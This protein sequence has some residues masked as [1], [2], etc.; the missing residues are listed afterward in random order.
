MR[1]LVSQ[2]RTSLSLVDECLRRIAELDSGRDGLGAVLALN[3]QARAQAEAADEQLERTGR[4]RGPLHGIP[5]LIKDVFETEGIPTTFGCA[6]F[7]GYVP[8]QDA[9]AVRRLRAAGAI[10]L[11]KTSTPDLAM[12]WLSDSSN[13]SN[14]VNSRS[15]AHE[16]GGSS[17]GSAVAVASGLAPAGLGSDT[18]GS[19]RVP[20]SF[21]GVVGLRP[22]TGLVSPDGMSSL[23][24]AQDTPGPLAGCVDDAAVLLQVLAG[25]QRPVDGARRPLGSYRLGVLALPAEPV[26]WDG[27]DEVAAVVDAALARLAGEGARILDDVVVPDLPALMRDSSLYLTTARDDIDAFL[28]SRP[29]LGSSSF[30]D[31]YYAEV[32]PE[33]LDLAELLATRSQSSVQLRAERLAN[34]RRLQDAVVREMRSLRLD[35]LV[36]PTVRVPAPLRDRNRESLPSRLLPVNTLIASQADLPA[37]TLPAGTTDA[38]LPVGLELLGRPGTDGPLLGL[39]RAVEGALRDG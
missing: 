3:P 24:T 12:S 4:Q 11:G 37:L 22:T 25:H 28:A 34:R 15:A 23:V 20:A 2:E 18:G 39:G 16:P 35:A 38:G 30:L 14:T 5:V 27:A 21:N 36:Y 7:Q 1:V 17:A 19:V 33:S 9:V 8:R 32:F 26:V 29:E 10:V 13:G 31:L 6:A